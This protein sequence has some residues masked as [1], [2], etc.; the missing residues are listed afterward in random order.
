MVQMHPYLSRVIKVKESIKRLE[1]RE[2]GSFYQVLS[3]DSNTKHGFNIHGVIFDELHAQ[4]NR[5][6]YDVITEA[7]G[8]ARDQPL[9]FT[10]TTAG[11]DMNSIG[12]VVHEHAKDIISGDRRDPSFYPVIYGATDE[13]DWTDPAVW[14]KANPSVDITVPMSRIEAMFESARGDAAKENN[15]RQL[16]LNQWVSSATRW[17][18]MFAWNACDFLVD[19]KMLAGRAC[20]AGLDLASTQDTT[21]LVLVFP[22]HESEK[23]GKF[24]VLPFFWLPEARLAPNIER[25]NIR[26]DDWVRDGILELTPGDVT[27]YAFVRKRILDLRKEFNLREVAV[28]PYNARHLLQELQGDG[29]NVLEFRQGAL[30]L[31]P[32]MKELMRF[33]FME[34]LAHG[35]NPMMDWQMDNLAVVTDANENIRPVKG[36]KRNGR[37]DGVVSLVMGL[38]RAILRQDINQ[39][40]AYDTREGLTIIG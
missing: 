25:D 38:D 36:K 8:D 11:N 31:S 3:A 40:S 28:D 17:M 21:A 2:S 26:Y 14:R 20:Y 22:P 1:H 10:L 35:G 34:K 6:L 39:A 30:S 19:R 24:H 27:D 29:V 4:P 9:Y 16:R 32:P 37:I 13:D 33:V 18:P 23:E 5:R 15:F 12:Y 7:S